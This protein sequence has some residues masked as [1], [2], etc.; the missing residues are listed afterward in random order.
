MD[1]QVEVY[2]G[3]WGMTV[4]R[5]GYTSPT[6][7]FPYHTTT[8]ALCCRIAHHHD[9]DNDHREMKIHGT[10][11]IFSFSLTRQTR[12]EARRKTRK[13]NQESLRERDSEGEGK[14]RV[15]G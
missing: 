5:V 10:F 6:T 8:R 11:V 12:R 1:G 13:G 15:R 2:R 3:N 9:K 7:L 4:Y 14:G